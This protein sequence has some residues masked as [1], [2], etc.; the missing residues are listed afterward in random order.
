MFQVD[1]WAY[2]VAAFLIL[3]LPLDWLLAA[4]MAAVFHEVCHAAAIWLLGGK[5]YRVR[6]GVGGADMETEIPDTKRELLCAAAG[7]VGSFLLLFLCRVFPKLAICACIHGLFNLLPVYPM[8]G[9]RMLRCLL[10]M[11]CPRYADRME[12]VVMIAAFSGMIGI[13]F[14]LSQGL[15]PTLIMS[16]WILKAIMRKRPCKWRQIRVQ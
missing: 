5:I 3:T 13:V 1:P 15:V 14:T 8:D 16:A 2:L 6:I 10:E 11:L 12:N 4:F 7:P 9:G